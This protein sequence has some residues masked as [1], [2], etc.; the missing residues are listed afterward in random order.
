MALFKWYVAKPGMYKATQMIAQDGRISNHIV[1]LNFH[2]FLRSEQLACLQKRA[3]ANSCRTDSV[4][5][6]FRQKFKF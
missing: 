2:Y 1:K 3:K 5:F 4:S 6:E